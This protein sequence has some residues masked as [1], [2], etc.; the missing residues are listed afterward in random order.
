MLRDFLQDVRVGLRI[1][2]RAPILTL[3]I[4]TTVGLGIGATTAI[5]AA[6]DAALLRPLPYAAPDRLVRVYTDTPP[7]KFRFSVADYLALRDQQTVFERI[8]TYTNRTMTFSDGTTAELLRGYQVSWTYFSVLGVTPALGR[9]F[10]EADGRP[11]STPM[12]L[13]SHGFWQ[14]RLGGRNDA[15]GRPIRLDG[16]DYTLAGVLPTRLGPLERNQEFFIVQQFSPPPRRGP[17]F[18]TVVA[19]LGPGVTPAVATEELH[20]INKRI[21]PI[22]KT[23]YQDDKAT[24]SLMDLRSHVVGNVSRIASLALA[25]VAL[26]WLIACA[27]ASNLLIARVTGRRRELAVRAALGASR[28]RVVRYLLAESTLLTIGSVA[29]GVAIATAGIGL[30]RGAG[31]TYFPR[32]QEVALEGRALWLLVGLTLASGA[33]F[34]L[35]PALQ[36]SRG[37]LDESLREGR[38]TTGGTAVRRLRRVLVGSQFAV[39]TPLLIVAALL[40]A[41][42]NALRHVDLGFDSRNV[43]TGSIRLPAAQ[44]SDIARTRAL[45]DEMARRMSSLPGVAAVGFA[46]GRPAGNVGNQ[47]NFDLEEHPTQPGQSQPVTPW[48]AVTPGYFRALGLTLLEGRL[49]DDRD[50]LAQNLESIVVDRAWARRFFPNG[51][52]VGKRLRE[53]GC[54]TCPWTTVVGVV[55]DVKY[56]GLDQPERGSVYSP[57]DGGS[58]RFLVVRTEASVQTVLPSLRNVVR[59]LEPGAPLTSVATIDD[60]VAQSLQGTQSLSL[61][62]GAFAAVALVLSVFGIYGVMAYY[63]QQHLKDIGIRIALGGSSADLLKLIVGQGMK[64]VGAGIAVGLAAAFGLARMAESLLFG[65]AAADPIVFAG[66]SGLLAAVALAGCLVPAMRAVAVHPAIVLR[67]E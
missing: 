9:D 28:A 56:V 67:S 18:Y 21:F 38:S 59:E 41:S 62:V 4:L 53:G 66:V 60:L 8:A 50:A 36:G 25:A 10:L 44:Y 15:I 22:W 5:F 7:F 31:A 61:L 40:F 29:L 27:N 39:A 17:F 45:W 42:L 63:V 6:V 51:S 13:V 57:M 23:S 32:M 64:V 52:A 3:T 16:N 35:M 49:L 26:V 47:N 1:L 46:D 24:W 20:A 2:S 43:V 14:R 19:R 48:V 33:M 12:A 11:G 54:T 55:S 58:S 30:L 37:G 34:G 65:V